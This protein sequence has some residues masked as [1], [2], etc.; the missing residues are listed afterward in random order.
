MATETEDDQEVKWTSAQLLDDRFETLWL[1]GMRRAGVQKNKAKDEFKK[2]MKK[3]K[4]PEKFLMMLIG[5]IH[6]RIVCLQPGFDALHMKRY[7]SN[8]RWEDEK[9]D[10]LPF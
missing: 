8:K 4:D 1:A 5:D 9:Q 10:H 3:E 2:L 7:L 6:A